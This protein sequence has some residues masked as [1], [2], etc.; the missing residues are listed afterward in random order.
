[1]KRAIVYINILVLSFSAGLSAQTVDDYEMHQ[2][3]SL[4]GLNKFGVYVWD[5]EGYHE[6]STLTIKDVETYIRKVLKN[7]GINSVSFSD[8]RELDGA[9][10]LEVSIKVEQ[11]QDKDS[12][13]YSTILRFIQDARLKRNNAPHYSAIVWERDDLGHADLRNLNLEIK[14]SLNSM[15]DEFL[16]DFSKVN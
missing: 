14:L 9:P 8:A 6:D 3:K 2:L 15:M 11:K 7:S 1:V 4:Q 10:N 13:V 12:Y 5:I 16:S